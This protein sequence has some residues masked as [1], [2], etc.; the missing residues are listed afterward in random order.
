MLLSP[1][2]APSLTL[3]I[4]PSR[5]LA[6]FLI[7]LHALAFIAAIANPLPIW[8]RAALLVFTIANFGYSFRQAVLRTAVTGLRCVPGQSWILYQ[9]EGESTRAQLST[10]TLVTPWLVLLHFQGERKKSSLLLCRDSLDAESFRRLRV[11]LAT[12]GGLP[13]STDPKPDEP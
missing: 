12:R 6:G 10:S 8:A 5:Q 7:L 2:S 11:L 4:R 1:K 3:E 9:R 13:A